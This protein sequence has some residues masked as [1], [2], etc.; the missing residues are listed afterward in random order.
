MTKIPQINLFNKVYQFSKNYLDFN[1][2][3]INI[4]DD[5]ISGFLILANMRVSLIL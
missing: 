5:L 4:N 2:Y 1:F 3:M